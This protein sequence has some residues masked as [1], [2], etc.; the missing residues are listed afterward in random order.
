MAGKKWLYLDSI[1]EEHYRDIIDARNPSFNYLIN[2]VP[3]LHVM[4][5]NLLSSC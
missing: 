3:F 2:G 4:E 5:Y 1:L